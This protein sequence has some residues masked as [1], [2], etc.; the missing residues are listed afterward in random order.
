LAELNPIGFRPGHSRL[1]RLDVRVKMGVLALLGVTASAAG[2]AG[3]ALLSVLVLAGIYDVRLA[4]GRLVGATRWLLIVLLLAAL[5]RSFSVPGDPLWKAGPLIL[6]R[7]GAVEGLGFTWRIMLVVLGGALLTSTTRTWA[8]RAA[9]AWLLSPL[10]GVP[11]RRVATMMGLLV[12]FIPEVIQQAAETR[13]A[14]RA[15]GIENARSP[16]RRMA[17]FCIGLMRRTLLRAD[18]LAMAMTARCYNDLRLD[19][20]LAFS[21]RDAVDLLALSLVCLVAACL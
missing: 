21:R 9:V 3:L 1:H 8:V 15:R 16:V 20:P 5:V 11:A 17:V 14:Q 2:P 19:P 4:M 12:R 7:Q 18:R 13:D 6:S 10:P